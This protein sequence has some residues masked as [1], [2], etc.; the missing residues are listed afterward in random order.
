MEKSSIIL[1]FLFTLFTINVKIIIRSDNMKENIIITNPITINFDFSSRINI[2]IGRNNSY[3]TT[4]LKQIKEQYEKDN[5]NILYFDEYR[6]MNVDKNDIETIDAIE[7]MQNR[8][9]LRERIK[10]I[11]DM[12]DD[13][14]LEN[15]KKE[16]NITCG[17]LQIV[18]FLYSIYLKTNEINNT[19]LMIDNFALNLHLMI[20][21]RL[22]D[23]LTL[24]CEIL[25]SSKVESSSHK[26]IKG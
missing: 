13:F 8:L 11:F 19:I 10:M 1:I 12:Q 3:K 22:L 4:I 14:V 25:P 21:N 9:T 5:E 23:V 7:I 18:I 15:L 20:L 6:K 16:D 17:Y 24:M 26:C 2:L